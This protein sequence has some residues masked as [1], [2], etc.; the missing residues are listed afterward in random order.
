MQIVCKFS[1]KR[2]SKI[3]KMKKAISI[4]LDN[5]RPKKNGKSPVKLRV[6]FS[7]DKSQKLY[8]LDFEYTADEFKN[9]WETIKP[10]KEFRED[11]LKLQEI[12]IRANEIAN[13]LKYF[14]PDLFEEAFFGN[15]SKKKRLTV[16]DYYDKAVEQ[17]KQ[18]DQIGTA[19]NYS[20]SL[21]SLL[22]FHK[23]SV[24]EFHNLTPQ[25][26]KKYEKFM[27]DDNDKSP[28]TVG[29]YLRPLRAICN[30][31][32][33]DRLIDAEEYPFGAKKYTI[34]APKGVKKALSKETLKKLFEGEAIAP[35]MK[36][37][38]AFWF[39]SFVCNG[40]NIKDI[41]QLRYKDIDGDKLS[42]RRAKTSHTDKTKR[43]ITVYL[44][45]FTHSVINEYGNKLKTSTNYIFP[46]LND[47]L[48]TEEKYAKTNNFVRYINQHFKKYAESVGV[49]EKV[50]TY[51]GRHS[52]ATRLI[53]EGGSIEMASEALGH[54][55]IGT[56]IGY[57]AGFEDTAKQEFANKIKPY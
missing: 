47:S 8:S 26:L 24:L 40:M 10:K 20:S 16:N 17:F 11:R 25:W 52:F 45:E 23:K 9:V 22:I 44:D 2:T 30:S 49:D 43:V 54:S 18:N 41:L 3:I 56:T 50:S 28:T 27:V 14:T 4:Y 38:K 13:G 35:D 21:K 1:G 5:R 6:F 37:A 12:E 53:Q 36:K 57:F 31:A 29:I 7:H 34:P 15:N 51:S 46:I 19:E 42:F 33:A 39:F 32:L 55:S 48:T